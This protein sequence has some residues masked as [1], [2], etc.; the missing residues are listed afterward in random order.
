MS[1]NIGSTP[2]VAIA[3]G[4]TPLVAIRIGSTLVWSSTPLR[5]D[6]N[7]DDEDA[8][9][10]PWINETP[11]AVY[12][13]GVEG[14][15]CRLVLPDGLTSQ[16]RVDSWFRHSTQFTADDGTLEIQVANNGSQD[17]VT[18]VWRRLSNNGTHAAGVG[19][20][21]SQSRAG[22]V[23]RVAGVD[24]IMDPG[25]FFTG[26][27]KLTL[28]QTGNV[29]TLS[30]GGH[31]IGE[32]DDTVGTAAKGAANRSI[33]IHVQAAKDALGP[34]RFSPSLNDIQAT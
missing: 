18:Q 15:A 4:S 19:I 8:L 29:H 1:I 25:G 10:A 2:V 5:D 31:V 7:R 30:K 27:S 24:T 13:A 17:Y 23:R 20:N 16:P 3:I 26:G 33:G 21:L 14:N 6:F 32:W 34:R 22:I 11:S 9:L 12:H 28:D